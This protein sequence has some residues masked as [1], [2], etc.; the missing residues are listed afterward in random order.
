MRLGSNPLKNKDE[1]TVALLPAITVGV[2]NFIPE[3]SGYF[4]E[5][6]D[7]LKLC[8]ASIR[9]NADQP[10]RLVVVDNGSYASVR[11]YLQRELDEGR[12]DQLI[13]NHGNMGKANA[14]LQILRSAPTEMIVYT[15]GDIYF[16]PD[17][18]AA[19]QAVVEAFPNAGMV[20]GVPLR[21]QAEFHTETT[22]KWVD[23]HQDELIITRGNL[24]PIDWTLEFITSVDPGNPQHYLDQWQELEDCR[25]ERDGVAA[26]VGA[27]HMQFATRREVIEQIPFQWFTHALHTDDDQLIDKAISEGGY[28]RLSTSEPF[29][30]HIGNRIAE[31]WLRAE[32]ERL[33]GEAAAENTR[34][35]GRSRHWF[36][37]RS[38]VRWLLNK[39]S[40]WTFNRLHTH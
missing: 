21:N 23:E 9:G 1:Q 31:D 15:D 33:L 35:A 28:L 16:R 13:L 7:A 36:W 39:L 27:S 25:I 29:V 32:Y 8:L 40:D 14:V 34:Q 30:Y 26:Y 11:D 19:H 18:V 20:G 24:I 5:S 12:I 6:L 22:L 17:W 38:R 4:R 2:L 10:V 37:G 3:Q